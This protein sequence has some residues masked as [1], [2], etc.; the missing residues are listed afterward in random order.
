[1]TQ[2]IIPRYKL[3]LFYDLA[4]EDTSAY[5]RFLMMEMIPSLQALGVYMFRAF[6]IIPAAPDSRSQMR[7]IEFVSEDLET[8]RDVLASPRWQNYEAWLLAHTTH[9]RKKIVPFRSGFQL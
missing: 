4:T 3:M 5:F 1:M 7:Q 8:L 2:R 9:Y 6:Q